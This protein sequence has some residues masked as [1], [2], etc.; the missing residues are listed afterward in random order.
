MVVM[1][2]LMLTVLAASALFGSCSK[3]D[4]DKIPN[5]E[6]LVSPELLNMAVSS[7]TAFTGGGDGL[8]LYAGYFHLYR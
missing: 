6:E 8:S 4:D 1:N 3:D 7:T 5:T 2:K